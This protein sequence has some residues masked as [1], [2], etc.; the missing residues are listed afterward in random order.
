MYSSTASTQ[1]LKFQSSAS[2]GCAPLDIDENL[3]EFHY[4]KGTNLNGKYEK[5]T[6]IRGKKGFIMIKMQPFLF[7]L[8]FEMQA[9][10]EKV[11]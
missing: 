4:S 11:T 5:G 9:S 7:I 3:M 1:L 6:I 2:T 10:V 8:N